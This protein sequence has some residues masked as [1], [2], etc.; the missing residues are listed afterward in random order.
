MVWTVWASVHRTPKSVPHSSPYLSKHTDLRIS[1]D[2]CWVSPWLVSW[3]EKSSCLTETETTCVYCWLSDVKKQENLMIE[4]NFFWNINTLFYKCWWWNLVKSI[5]PM[6][7]DTQRRNNNLQNRG[8]GVLFW[9]VFLGFGL[10]LVFFFFFYF[11]SFLN[12]Q[13]DHQ[14]IQIWCHVQLLQQKT[15]CINFTV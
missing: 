3:I 12:R 9:G 4:L 1:G 11:W 2:T 10:V 8:G 7:L 14:L 13:Q 6:E 5:F 15:F